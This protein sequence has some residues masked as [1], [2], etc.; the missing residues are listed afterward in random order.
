MNSFYLAEG[1]AF[2]YIV[3]HGTKLKKHAV[4]L[5]INL[6]A[7]IGTQSLLSLSLLLLF[8]LAR[9]AEDGKRRVYLSTH[10]ITEWLFLILFRFSC[11]RGGNQTD[12]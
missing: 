5:R 12:E 10:G 7:V 11:A 9:R 4:N 8:C 2:L 6:A 1:E 3:R